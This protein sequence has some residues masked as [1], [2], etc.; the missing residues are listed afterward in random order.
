[1][2]CLLSS[3]RTLIEAW[4][5]KTLQH[6]VLLCF[7]IS[8]MLDCYTV[9]N[10]GWIVYTVVVLYIRG[11]GGFCPRISP[12]KPASHFQF[13]SIV[14]EYKPLLTSYKISKKIYLT[15]FSTY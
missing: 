2:Q 5:F 7:V 4:N 6:L 8:A 10:N 1:M 15:E 12:K 11:L 13:G 3:H 9:L 14:E